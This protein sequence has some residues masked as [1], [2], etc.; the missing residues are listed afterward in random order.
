MALV[1]PPFKEYHDGKSRTK[2]DWPYE[3]HP[4]RERISLVS[5]PSVLIFWRKIFWTPLHTRSTTPPQPTIA[6]S[7]QSERCRDGKTTL[8]G[9]VSCP[10]ARDESSTPAA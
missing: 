9:L 10:A 3:M 7:G 8:G 5:I 4:P 1:R 6:N 2:Q